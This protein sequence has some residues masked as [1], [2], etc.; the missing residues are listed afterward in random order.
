LSSNK[1][2][3]GV[4]LKATEDDTQMFL[5]SLSLALSATRKATDGHPA[6]IRLL[7]NRL[8]NQWFNTVLSVRSSSPDLLIRWWGTL[9]HLVNHTSHDISRR[10][11]ANIHGLYD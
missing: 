6:V 4:E 3:T 10:D 11:T 9:N 8:T 5:V 1:D 2:E 7:E